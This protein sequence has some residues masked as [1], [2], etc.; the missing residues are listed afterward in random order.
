MRI[1]KLS[2]ILAVILFL[3]ISLGIIYFGFLT[4]PAYFPNGSL[5]T[6][7][8]G[9]GLTATANDLESKQIIRSPFW[10]KGLVVIMA[11]PKGLMAG[12]YVLFQNQNVITLAY[13]LTR[14]DFGLKPIS[15][16]LREG[17]SVSEMAQLLS[18]KFTK[19]IA[20]DFI[21]LA[22]PDEGYLFPDTYL[23]LPNARSA[24]VISTMK[25]NFQRKISSFNT[26]INDF[27]KP[28]VDIIKMASILELEARTLESKRMIADILWRRIELGM[29]L[30]VDVSF[31]YINGKTTKSL[32]T[33]DLKIDSPYNSYVYKGLPPTPISNP[34]LD[35]IKA[36]VTPIKTN[37]LYFLSDKAGNM[38]YAKTYKEHLQNKEIYLR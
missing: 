17:L 4:T 34:G 9:S 12:D 25:Q 26:E 28:L 1:T 14:G 20:V 8:S 18:K 5:Y 27:N 29:P 2:I 30:Q 19:V 7:T 16:T 13:R 22:K 21:E 36:A 31:K 3:L 37:Y 11:G 23:F 33:T 10:F 24:E 6:I 32:T 38:H 15:I 35:S